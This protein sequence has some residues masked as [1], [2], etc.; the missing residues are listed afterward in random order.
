MGLTPHV[1]ALGLLG[2]LIRPIRARLPLLLWALPILLYL[3]FGSMSASEYVPILKRERFLL[4]L[5]IPLSLLGGSVATSLAQVLGG[6]RRGLPAIL[7]TL[8]VVCFAAASWVIV[9]AERNTGAERDRAFRE[10]VRVAEAEPRLPVLFDHWRTGY[11]FSY[12]FGFREGAGFYRGGADADRVGRPG[13]FGASRLGYLKWY[14]QA[15]QVPPGFVVLDDEVQNRI[16][17]GDSVT[18]TYRPGDVPSY[19]QAPP[20]DWRKVG[21]FGTFTVYRVQ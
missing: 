12:Y 9:A 4:P 3:Q 1:F 11:R 15:E 21:R 7:L 6:R 13:D 14:P 5:T 2:T 19:A 10:V 18:R 17:A 20:A 16:Q 8:G